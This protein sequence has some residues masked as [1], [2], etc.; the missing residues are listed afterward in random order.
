MYAFL[1]SVR[2]SFLYKILYFLSVAYMEYLLFIKYYN[3]MKL[4]GKN[5]WKCLLILAIG[6]FLLKY[7]LL[8]NK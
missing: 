5:A 6:I 7:C 1:E 4:T 3:E 8:F 2:D